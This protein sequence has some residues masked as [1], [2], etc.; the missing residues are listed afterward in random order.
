MLA[1]VGCYRQEQWARPGDHHTVARDGQAAL[2]HGLQPARSHYVGQG[3]TGKREKSLARAGR[4][5][6]LVMP[7][8][9]E[10]VPR[11]G[12]Q[13]AGFELV[14]D[15]R[16]CQNY[17]AG[18]LEALKPLRGVEHGTILQTLPPDLATQVDVI[19]DDADARSAVCGAHRGRQPGRATADYQNIELANANHWFEGP[20]PVRTGFGNSGCGVFH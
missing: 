16:A 11:F 1:Q 9:A 19:V 15:P 5:N 17:N 6:E 12:E 3:P 14:E 20:S 10:V 2:D 7:Q 4:Q 8:L 13:D 18:G